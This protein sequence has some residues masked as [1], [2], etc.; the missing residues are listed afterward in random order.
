M[1]LKN[2]L[3]GI[4]A[5]G[6]M[7][8]PNEI[9]AQKYALS[10]STRERL[11]NVVAKLSSEPRPPSE[12]DYIDN[13]SG[14]C[15]RYKKVKIGNEV[16][17]ICLTMNLL[18]PE[19][20]RYELREENGNLVCNLPNISRHPPI[21]IDFRDVNNDKYNDLI[22]AY[23]K[24]K[25]PNKKINE[26]S[27]K[28]NEYNIFVC[29]GQKGNFSSPERL[30]YEENRKEFNTMLELI[31]QKEESLSKALSQVQEE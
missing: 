16:K 13:F 6:S 1:G 5:A 25:S 7:L 2:Y 9:G 18:V 31:A 26:S 23:K 3:V 10:D 11:E 8:L 30:A 27:N 17:N 14:N 22:L 15:G 29:Y 21:A 4:L 12:A 19:K 24:Y 28:V 20:V